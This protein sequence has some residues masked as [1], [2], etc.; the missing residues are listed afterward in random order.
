MRAILFDLLVMWLSI[1]IGA[2]AWPDIPVLV[3]GAVVFLVTSV[4]WL[5][6]DMWYAIK[7]AN[8]DRNSR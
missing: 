3:F 5:V 7:E 1:V 8:H 2:Y 4:C 6:M